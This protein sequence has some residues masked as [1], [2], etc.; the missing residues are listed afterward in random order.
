MRSHG[1]ATVWGAHIGLGRVNQGTSWYQRLKEWWAARTAARQQARI[2][3]LHACWDA[4]REVVRP[5]RAEAAIEMA[6]AQGALAMATDPLSLS[7]E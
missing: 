4:K 6:I 5:L 7:R 1:H 3:A 2:A